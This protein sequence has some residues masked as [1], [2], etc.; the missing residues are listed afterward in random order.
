MIEQSGSS[1]MLSLADLERIALFYNF[2]TQLIKVEPSYFWSRP[3]S[4]ILHLTEQHFVVFIKAVD[5]GAVIFD[6]EYGQVYV[7]W[8][9]LSK[10]FSGYMLY[11]Y[12]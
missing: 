4:A 9:T 3:V 6:P 1:S 10:L 8:K 12:N 5:N 11:L 7:A 2:K